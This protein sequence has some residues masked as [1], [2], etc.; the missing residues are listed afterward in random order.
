MTNDRNTETNG[1]DG[2]CVCSHVGRGR[3]RASMCAHAQWEEAVYQPYNP[4]V[5]KD[6]KSSPA[7]GHSLD[8]LCL[9]RYARAQGLLMKQC[10]Y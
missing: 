10:H 5:Q 2:A 3:V 8:I 7:S 9:L 6:S 4:F 1:C